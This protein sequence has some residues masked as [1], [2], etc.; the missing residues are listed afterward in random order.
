MSGTTNNGQKADRWLRWTACYSKIN[1]KWL[2]VHEQVSVPFDL[3]NGKA[4]MDLK[5]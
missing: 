3:R 1:G 2:I 5:P 4:M